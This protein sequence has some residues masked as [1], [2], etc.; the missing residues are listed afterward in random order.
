MT[1]GV[2]VQKVQSA[3]SNGHKP[4]TVISQIISEMQSL[5]GSSFEVYTKTM[6]D[7]LIGQLSR[8]EMKSMLLT[9]A[10]KSNFDKL[11]NSI[12]FHILKLMQKNN[13]TSSALHHLPWFKRKKVDNSLFLHKKI[14]SQNAQV[15]LIKR[16]VMSLSYKDRARIKTALKEKPVTPSL[17]S[18]LL[19]ETRIAK[20]PKIPVSRDKL[21]S[22]FVND[23][24]AG[25]VAPLACE[26]LELPDSES[27]KER[28]TAIS[29]ENGLLGGVQKGVSDIILAGLESHLK[30]ILSR[31][32][33]ILN[34]NIRQKNTEND[35]AGFTI[36]DLN[37]A[38]T[39]EPHAFVEQYPQKLRMPF[40]LHDSYTEDEISICAE[41]PSYMLA[42]NDAQS[43]RNSVA[44]LL[45]EVLS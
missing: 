17:I 31:C 34:K 24:K 6:T 13:D 19:L 25:Y 14:S 35:A 9:F 36:N 7:F 32:F 10:G 21:N 26:T 22:V 4:N 30:N 20:L 15:R 23:I 45:D 12:I 1:E 44:S 11:H 5:L 16:I 2:T 43:D 18:G 8:K 41:S 37:L 29:L 33:S 38:W 28:I 42:S 27:L 3:S 40:L 39:I